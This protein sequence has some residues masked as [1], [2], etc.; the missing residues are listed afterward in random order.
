[1]ALNG[2]GVRDTARVRG[3][4]PNA[5]LQGIWTVASRFLSL[6][7]HMS[8]GPEIDEVCPLCN[9]SS[10]NIGA[11]M[12]GITNASRLRRLCGDAVPMRTAAA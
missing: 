8:R 5:A 10:S 4:S 9:P 1:M 6:R 12:V 7:H 2:S 11:G 3:I